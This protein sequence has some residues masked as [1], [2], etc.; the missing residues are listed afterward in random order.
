MLHNCISNS[1][2]HL[3]VVSATRVRKRDVL[4]LKRSV[5]CTARVNKR[6]ALVPVSLVRT[7][8]SFL[9]AE[10]GYVAKDPKDN[11]GVSDCFAD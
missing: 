1:V 4:L 6:Q 11:D 10:R 7:T 9:A 2:N 8:S 3:Q 5:F